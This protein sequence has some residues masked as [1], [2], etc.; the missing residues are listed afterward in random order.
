MIK[1]RMTRGGR[2][3]RP[4]Y[5]IVAADHRSPRDGKFLAKLG[6][7]NPHSKTEVLKDIKTDEIKTWVTNGAQ[8]SDTVASLFKKHNIQL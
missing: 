8:L 5:T 7:Y 3:A 2:K 6:Q 1:I 4:V